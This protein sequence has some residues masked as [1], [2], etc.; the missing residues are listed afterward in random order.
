M[1]IETETGVVSY[2]DKLT[3]DQ[4]QTAL[5]RDVWLIHNRWES[6]ARVEEVL[7]RLKSL[8]ILPRRELRFQVRHQ[9]QIKVRTRQ[10]N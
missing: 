7:Q 3:Q 8:G 5:R 10:G 9:G 2:S 1:L 6:P 4:L